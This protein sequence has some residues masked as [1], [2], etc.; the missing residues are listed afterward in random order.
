[1]ITKS[2]HLTDDYNKIISEYF[3]A[4]GTS[5]VSFVGIMLF[6]SAVLAFGDTRG[7]L[8]DSLGNKVLEKGRIV[9]KVFR[10]GNSVLVTYGQNKLLEWSMTI[11]LEDYLNN[12]LEEGR[13]LEYIFD[14]MNEIIIHAHRGQQQFNF[15]VGG[16]D[17]NGTY[18]R[19]VTIGMNGILIGN[20][21]RKSI[22][23]DVSLVD[24]FSDWFQSVF[25]SLKYQ[26]LEPEEVRSALSKML[27]DKIQEAEKNTDY[28]TV[29]LPLQFEI[30]Q[31]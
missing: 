10:T 6:D 27:T 15:I 19:E 8:K 28:L 11:N 24:G 18:F 26:R 16:K 20:K 9:Q 7:T 5:E 2:Y 14:E 23:F 21:K 17:D 29:G 12:R 25:S 31:F 4:K 22:G 30:I 1:M 3:S 13:T